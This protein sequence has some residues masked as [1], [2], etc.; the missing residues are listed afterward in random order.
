MSMSSRILIMFSNLVGLLGNVYNLEIIKLYR[1][2][3][4]ERYWRFDVHQ[5]EQ[6]KKNSQKGN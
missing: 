1:Y 2:I 6:W 3:F 4:L 5:E